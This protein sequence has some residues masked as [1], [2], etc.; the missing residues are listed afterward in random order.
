MDTLI[1]A[2]IIVF[3]IVLSVV[4]ILLKRING[5]I[6]DAALKVDFFDQKLDAE[7]EKILTTMNQQYTDI[8]T[9]VKKLGEEKVEAQRL[10]D[11]ELYEEAKEYVIETERASASLLQRH[12]R[13]GYARAAML[14]DM[15]E[16]KGIIGPGDGAKPRT[17]LI[18]K[19]EEEV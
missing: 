9:S 8:L 19:E 4:L 5:K 12:L 16:E 13:I 18:L 14:L 1:Y 17:V 10:N 6:N 15:L 2:A 7:N 3:A 11:E